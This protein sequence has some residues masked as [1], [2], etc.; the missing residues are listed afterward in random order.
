MNQ[1]VGIFNDTHQSLFN[2]TISPLGGMTTATTLD[3]NVVESISE[4]GGDDNEN[5]SIALAIA[6]SSCF[7][8]LQ[9]P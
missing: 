6:G 4:A 3:E 8:L 7:R 2:D 9:L 1:S 5:V